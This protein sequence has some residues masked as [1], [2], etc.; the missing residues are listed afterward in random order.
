MRPPKWERLEP[1]VYRWLGQNSKGTF[2]ASVERGCDKHTRYPRWY[3]RAIDIHSDQPS[4]VGYE[5]SLKEARKSAM[6]AL[7]QLSNG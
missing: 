6:E 5:L 3:W 7:D 2:L 4:K 1:G